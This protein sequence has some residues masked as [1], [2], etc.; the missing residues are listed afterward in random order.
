MR[1]GSETCFHEVALQD[2]HMRASDACFRK[3]NILAKTKIA[4]RHLNMHVLG[5]L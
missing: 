2:L 3:D 5:V 1:D 4:S